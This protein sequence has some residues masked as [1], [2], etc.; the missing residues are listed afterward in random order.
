MGGCADCAA[1]ADAAA[2]RGGK[3]L[4]LLII[5]YQKSGLARLKRPT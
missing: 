1:L 5:E 4:Y 2:Q 3:S